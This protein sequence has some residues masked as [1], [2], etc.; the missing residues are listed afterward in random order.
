[1]APGLFVP[2]LTVMGL[3]ETRSAPPPAPLATIVSCSLVCAVR[4]VAASYARLKI[5]AP[6]V[7]VLAANVEA[8]AVNVPFRLNTA[9]PSALAWTGTLSAPAMAW[10]PVSVELVMLSWPSHVEDGTAHPRP[11][12]AGRVG[13][14]GT[15]TAAETTKATAAASA[16]AE[17]AVTTV[18]GGVGNGGDAVTPPAAE[19]SAATARAILLGGGG[20]GGAAA[21]THAA[22]PATEAE[23][24]ACLAIAGT[25]T[26]TAVPAGTA[27]DVDRGAA[28]ATHPRQRATTA[29]PWGP[30]SWAAVLGQGEPRSAAVAHDEVRAHV[31]AICT[32]T[33]AG[34]P[35]GAGAETAARLTIRARPD[36]APAVA[37]GGVS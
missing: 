6:S 2:P 10:L 32:I 1:M 26:A 9:P 33:A 23:A 4:A 13:A 22:A 21:T 34:A 19:A 16:S 17:A 25:A 30:R 29:A 5:A 24:A 37:S 15:V 8:T 35:E 12:A 18:A 36:A 14:A 27:R 20:A 7:A 31:V 11:A 28:G 3:S